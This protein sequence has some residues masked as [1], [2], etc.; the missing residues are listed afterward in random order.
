MHD[1]DFLHQ[2][3]NWANKWTGLRDKLTAAFFN[4][5]DISAFAVS[6]PYGFMQSSSRSLLNTI[7]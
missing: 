6:E 3:G 5:T 1:G 4:F 7:T 2:E